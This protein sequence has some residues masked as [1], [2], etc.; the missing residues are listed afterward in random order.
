MGGSAAGVRRYRRGWLGGVLAVTTA[1]LTA[2]ALAHPVLPV[3][4]TVVRAGSDLAAVAALG[5][6]VV[7]LLDQSRYR[8]ELANRARRPLIA[9]GAVWLVAELAA[10]ILAATQ[11]VG[12]SAAALS[13][14]AALQFATT[15]AA[16]R[17]A[18]FGVAAAG[19]VLVLA[20]ATGTGP[21]RGRGLITAAAAGVAGRALTG[22]LAGTLLAGVAVVAHA[23]AAALWCGALL[24][25]ALTVRARGQWARVL[26]AFSHLALWCVGVLL[27]GGL[28]AAA[29]ALDSPADLYGTGHGRILLAKVAVTAGLLALAWRNRMHWLVGARRHQLRAEQSLT[30]A[31]TELV[32]MAGALTLAAALTTTG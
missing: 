15:T 23:L 20:T 1:L 9:V 11:A 13:V 22:H 14:P 12:V 19:T 28:L 3:A 16:G 29:T 32:L 8:A 7:P 10:L 31:G 24:A 18:L 17:A 25:L 6:S 2:W 21:L 30:R 4:G 26:P 27:T 5:L